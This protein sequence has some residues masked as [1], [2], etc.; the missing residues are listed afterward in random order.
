MMDVVSKIPLPKFVD[1][2]PSYALKAQRRASESFDGRDLL[3]RV[4]AR[5]LIVR[6][7]RDRVVSASDTVEL[8]AIP[9][10]KL[11]DL[12]GGHITM[13]SLHMSDF[14]DAVCSFLDSTP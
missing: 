3:P 13:M 7:R 2:Q 14:V 8:G 9:G 5:T 1:D 4:T 6:A 10:S 12:P 11:I